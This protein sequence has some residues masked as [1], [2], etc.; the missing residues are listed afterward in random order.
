MYSV[1]CR[2]PPRVVRVGVELL[3]DL[4]DVVVVAARGPGRG[5]RCWARSRPRAGCR[6][7]AAP[8][9]RRRC[10]GRRRPASARCRGA[11]RARRTRACAGA[12]CRPASCRGVRRSL[13]RQ[14]HRAERRGDQQRAVNSN[15]EDVLAEHQRGKAVRVAVGV[16]ARRGRRPAPATVWPI[17]STAMMPKTRP[18]TRG[19][20]PLAADRL[21]QRLGGVDAHQHQD[22]QEQHHDRAGVDDDLHRE[23]ERRALRGVQ[24]RQADHHDRQAQRRVHGLAANSSPSAAIT[25]IGARIQ[26]VVTRSSPS[27]GPDETPTIG[28]CLPR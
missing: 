4:L 6:R 27:V 7:A 16:G 3:D 8:G 14:H 10:G 18:T 1:T 2:L 25:M 15:G 20:E 21:A 23:Q 13:V 22:E 19:G 12:A 11:C 28:S 17:A 24:D 5:R 26:N 9:C